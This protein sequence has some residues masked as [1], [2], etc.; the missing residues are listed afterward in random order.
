MLAS[1]LATQVVLICQSPLIYP[2]TPFLM[3]G[4][5]TN[6][7]MFMLPGFWVTTCLGRTRSLPQTILDHLWSTLLLLF[8]LIA[9][10][11]LLS[12]V[13]LFHDSFT[14]WSFWGAYSFVMEGI[15]IAAVLRKKNPRHVLKGVIGRRKALVALGTTASIYLLTFWGATRVVPMQQDQDMVLVCPTDGI[16]SHLV[17]Y[18]L[19]TR[20]PYQFNKPPALYFFTGAS[21]LLRG[22]LGLA[23]PFCTSGQNAL[24]VFDLPARARKE[25]LAAMRDH[26]IKRFFKTPRLTA[27]VRIATLGIAAILACTFVL[28][29]MERQLPM[30][31]SALS[32]VTVFS[33]P[34]MFIRSSYAGFTSITLLE[35]LLLTWLYLRRN[36]QCRAFSKALFFAATLLALTNHKALL[37]VPA[38]AFAD[39]IVCG[40]HA[41]VLRTAKAWIIQL[42]RTGVVPGAVFGTLLYW[43][44]GLSIN[45]RIFLDDHVFYDF[46]D[47]FT[48]GFDATYPTLGQLWWQ[49]LRNLSFVTLPIGMI[50]LFVLLARGP[51][52]FVVLGFW[53]AL[54]SVLASV[55]DWKQT[56]HLMQVFLPVVMAPALCWN[57]VGKPIQRILLLLWIITLL[58]NA[59]IIYR[60][61]LDFSFLPPSKVW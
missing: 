21:V 46:I 36:K 55:V 59:Y 50:F 34:E 20:F 51:R 13:G 10:R 19:E 53:F 32:T 6:L 23:R 26:D 48:R 44:Y 35:L 12:Q 41:S 15:L 38:F 16:Y 40:R 57:M 31:V 58:I 30:W 28:F 4:V 37:V 27:S 45:F 39:L 60:L 49:W 47:R 9:A 61:A 54:G 43:L 7:F 3:Q 29:L 1:M 2:F 25:I 5:V 22:E 24:P 14:A 42:W 52:R 11:L 8:G 18:G 17:P 33:L 56:K